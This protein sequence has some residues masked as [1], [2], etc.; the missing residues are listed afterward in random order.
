MTR[1]RGKK[2]NHYLVTVGLVSGKE[3]RYNRWN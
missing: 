2:G 1:I 3:T